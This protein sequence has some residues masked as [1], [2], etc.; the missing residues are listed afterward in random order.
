MGGSSDARKT[1]L[2]TYEISQ[3][4]L[5]VTMG[6][7][8]GSVYRWFHGKRDPTAETVVEIVEALKVLN[9]EAA[10]KFVQLYLGDVLN[11]IEC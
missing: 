5:A 1:V 6:V 11:N 10:E 2:E 8:R 3:N 4:N 7:E 9:P